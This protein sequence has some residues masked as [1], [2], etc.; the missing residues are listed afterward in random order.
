MPEQDLSD[1]ASQFKKAYLFERWKEAIEL[2]E[3]L[4]KTDASKLNDVLISTKDL[5]DQCQIIKKEVVKLVKDG[6]TRDGFKFRILIR[7]AEKIIG[8]L[9]GEY[10]SFVFDQETEKRERKLRGEQADNST[11]R[12]STP[13]PA[14]LPSAISSK[15]FSSKPTNTPLP[16]K[17]PIVAPHSS[18]QPEKQP[19]KQPVPSSSSSSSLSS[20]S[21][22][23][24]SPSA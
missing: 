23:T 19:E 5:F 15:A 21:S 9:A 11:E 10:L 24:T 8:S 2:K 6:G 22:A 13:P 3:E 4:R 12:S 14:L 20:S 1:F 7:N 16:P 17:A 18:K